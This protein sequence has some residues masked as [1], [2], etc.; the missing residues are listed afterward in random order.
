MKNLRA[1]VLVVLLGFSDAAAEPSDATVPTTPI[2]PPG[3]AAAREVTGL[4][5]PAARPAPTGPTTPIVPPGLAATPGIAEP[6]APVAPPAAEVIDPSKK[7][8]AY[9]GAMSRFLAAEQNDALAKIDDVPRRHL[10]M[11]YYLRAGPSIASRWS[12]TTEQ[13]AKYEKSPEYAAALAELEK[14]STQF[15]AD[16]PGYVLHVNSRV[17][18]LEE[19]VSLWQ[20]TDSVGKAAS[21]L[22]DAAL[23]TLANDKYGDA[24]DAASIKRFR[25]FLDVWRPTT[26]LTLVAPG[27]SLHGRGRAYDFQIRDKDGRTVAEPVASTVQK[28]WTEGGWAEKLSL[29]VHTASDKF[30][31]PLLSPPEPW[32]YEYKPT[33]PG[34]SPAG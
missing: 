14:I 1:V 5:D 10:A 34:K 32:H 23:K 33:A 24:P 27:L 11:T 19:Q 21:E 25:T 13:I 26:R 8:E 7:L 4:L 22:N 31:G 9:M 16:N 12:W 30:V 28:V 29:A 6:P 2:V 15:A 3:S 17:R 18:S 20:A